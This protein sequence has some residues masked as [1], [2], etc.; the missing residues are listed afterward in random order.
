[1]KFLSDELPFDSKLTHKS[2]IT[3]DKDTLQIKSMVN[4]LVSVSSKS[5]EYPD[6][7]HVQGNILEYYWK[8]LLITYGTISFDN[9][10]DRIKNNC[11]Y[12]SSKCMRFIV[13]ECFGTDY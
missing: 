7:A 10:L 11:R 3:F 9:D 8:P 1:M 5:N 13:N 4:K 12:V 2:I 6:D